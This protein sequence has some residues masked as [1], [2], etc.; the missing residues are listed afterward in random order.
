MTSLE[1]WGSTI[2]LH[3]QEKQER[4]MSR[5]LLFSSAYSKKGDYA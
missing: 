3:P 2:E 4:T 5:T 1:G